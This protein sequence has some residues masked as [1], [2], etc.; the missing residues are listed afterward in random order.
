MP[1]R[2]TMQTPTTRPAPLRTATWLTPGQVAPLFSLPDSDMERVDLARYRGRSNVVLYFYPRDG[3]PAC[4]LQATDFSDHE[5]EFAQHDCVVL[6]V[7]P[8]DCLCHAEFRDANGVSIVLLA[9][10]ECEVCTKYG[11]VEPGEAAVIARANAREGAYEGAYEG[12]N[13]GNGNGRGA[14]RL[15]L[16]AHDL[17]NGM[18]SGA[19]HAARAPRPITRATF[20]IDKRGVVR[21]ALYNVSPRGHVAQVLGLVRGLGR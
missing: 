19:V 21:H 6:G 9:D 1:G 18:T 13:A 12:G 4:T 10:T 7:S 8:D 5:D 2:M 3:T 11:V 16:N 17:H 14:G 15:G 20:V